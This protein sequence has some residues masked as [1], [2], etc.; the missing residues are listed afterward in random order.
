MVIGAHG[1][2]RLFDELLNAQWQPE[3]VGPFGIWKSV[4]PWPHPIRP[5]AGTR[6]TDGDLDALAA[7]LAEL[8]LNPNIEWV[9]DEHPELEGL[10]AARGAEIVRTPALVYNEAAPVVTPSLP[11]R[12]RVFRQTSTDS[13]E[14]ILAARA[15]GDLGFGNAGLHIGSVGAV[16]R[17]AQVA[18]GLASD[19]GRAY[20]DY[21]R[22]RLASDD[23][24]MFVIADE[25]G[26]VARAAVLSGAAGSEIAGVA[27][28]PAY[29]RQ[30]LAAVITHA[31]IAYVSSTGKLPLALTA[32][33]ADVA[34]V[35]ERL[36]FVRVAT[37]GESQLP[38]VSEPISTP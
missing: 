2:A 16:E 28:L 11:P 38:V 26:L 3:I 31:A 10:L 17:D 6:V 19:A 27:T 34:R 20:V 12:F 21:S 13:P 18:E 7:R 14:E 32:A 15:V 29:R 37:A 22:L 4:A 9:L 8:G 5:L 1:V 30:G 25:G 35:Y 33:D 24:A 23:F 36:G